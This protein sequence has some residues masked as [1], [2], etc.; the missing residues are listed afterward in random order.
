MN[1]RPEPVCVQRTGRKEFGALKLLTNPALHLCEQNVRQLYI[2]FK[3]I[4]RGDNDLFVEKE[5]GVRLIIARN[6]LDK[7]RT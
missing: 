3:K 6:I 7:C 5:G 2:F 4:S 1:G